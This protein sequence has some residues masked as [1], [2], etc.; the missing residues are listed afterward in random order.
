MKNEFKLKLVNLRKSLEKGD[1]GTIA[2]RGGISV[3]TVQ[4]MFKVNEYCDMKPAMKK[5]LDATINFVDEKKR[6][7]NK[8][9][10]KIMGL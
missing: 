3:V 5:A 9:L 10:E 1:L 6:I 7:N 4:Q 8:A 2:H